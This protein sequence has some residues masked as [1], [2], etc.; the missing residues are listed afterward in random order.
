MADC[1]VEAGQLTVGAIATQPRHNGEPAFNSHALVL[2]FDTQLEPHRSRTSV[3]SSFLRRPFSGISLAS[4]GSES[5]SSDDIRGPLGLCLLHEPP[6]PLIDF[7]FVHGL[8][9]G[10]R[11]TWSKTDDPT[12]FWPKAWLPKEPRFKNVRIF[13]FGYNSN[14]IN[15]KG[16]TLTIHDFGQALLGDIQ[17]TLSS[18]RN[19]SET[20]L[21][22][23]AHSMGGVIIK[24]VLLLAKQD[25]LYHR[26]AARTHSMFFLA[27]PHRGADSAQLLSNMLTIAVSHGSKPYVDNLM[28]GSDAIQVINDGFRHVLQGIQLWS[29][30]E[31]VKTSLGLIVPKDSAILDLPGERVQLSNAD[32]R[33]ICKFEDPSD[34]NYC[35]LRNAF[36]STIDCIENTWY[37]DKQ[38]D[39]R[40]EMTLLSTYLGLLETPDVDLAN[41]LE[42][43]TE[44]TCRWITES[45]TFQ[46]WRLGLEDEPK[47]YWL[48]GDPATGKSTLAG[49]VVQHLEETQRECSYFFFKNSSVGRSTVAELLRSLAWQMASSISAVRQ[50]L[51]ALQTDGVS[52]DKDDERSIRRTIFVARIFRTDLRQPHYWIID[53][54]DECANPTALFPLLSKIEKQYPLLVFLTSRPSLVFERYLSQEK[55]HHFSETAGL[56][57]SLNDITL[58]ISAHAHYIPVETDVERDELSRTILEKSRGNFLWVRLILKELEAAVSKQ[59]ISEILESVPKEIDDLYTRILGKLMSSARAT[60]LVT[61]TLRWVVCASRPLTVDEMKDVLRLEIGE[62]LP[63]LEKTAT[64]ICGNLIY[65]DYQLKIRL[66]HHTVREY[67]SRETS[68]APFSI[69]RTNVHSQMARFCLKYLRSEEMKTLRRGRGSLASRQRQRSPISTYVTRHFSD[70]LARSSSSED[71]HLLDLYAFLKGNSL[72]WLEIVAA[73]QDLSPVVATAKNLKTYLERRARYLPPI[74]KE[75]QSVSGWANDMI[76]VVAQY[77]KIMLTSPTAVHFLIP[78][79][80][81]AG[82]II[83]ELF[84]DQNR[85]LQVAGLSEVQWDD[86]LCTISFAKAQILAVVCRDNKYALGLSDGFVNMYDESSF[87][88][89]SKLAHGEPVRVLSFSSTNTYLASAGRKTI[90]MWNSSTAVLIWTV[91]ISEQVL[92]LDFVGNDRILMAATKMNSLCSWDVETGSEEDKVRFSDIDE[93]DQSDYYYKRPPLYAEISPSLNLLGVA[94]KN[95]PVSFWDLED[96]VFVGQYHKDGAAFPEALVQDF[97]FNPNPELSLVA[98]VYEDGQVDTFDPFT[99]MRESTAESNASTLASS[100]DGTVLLSGSSDG[101]IRIYEFET[102]KLCYQIN[103]DQQYIRALAFDSNNI[104]FLDIRSKQC[105]VW[106]PSVLVRRRGPEDDSSLN[107]SASLTGGPELI[108][109]RIFD[110]DLDITAIAAYDG[111]DCV[112]CGRENGSVAL[113]S[114]KTGQLVQE[115]FTL[116]TFVAVIYFEWNQQESLLVAL[117][118][119]GGYEIQRLTRDALGQFSSSVLFRRL[120]NDVQQLLL[121]PDGAQLLIS[122]SEADELWTT[123]SNALQR[124]LNARPRNTGRWMC[125][126]RSIGKLLF[127]SDKRLRIFDWEN[128]DEL[129]KGEGIDLKMSSAPTQPLSLCTS[130]PRGQNI[131]ACFIGTETPELVPALRLWPSEKLDP[132]G[133]IAEPAAAYDDLA[134]EIKHVVGIYK[135]LLVFLNHQGWICSLNIDDISVDGFYTRHFFIPLQWH[136]TAAEMPIMVTSKGVIMI[137]VKHEVA[138]F[139]NGFDFSERVTFEGTK[140]SAKASMRSVFKGGNSDPP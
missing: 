24:K 136:G 10:S 123:E 37:S 59:H 120:T 9:G 14:W 64:S 30:F 52:I 106:E 47:N 61:T 109:T 76:R 29:F 63:Q 78:P 27:T 135:S 54:L 72:T 44:G 86:R 91:E 119:S 41:V 103:S 108:A 125:H 131:C 67:L 69:Q 49:H 26:I 7:I 32:H 93:E 100:H 92:A 6:E 79:V 34:S 97:I 82:T 101:L 134:K 17:T 5:E 130:S 25:P 140:I 66:A 139:Q 124:S 43:R 11:K 4:R 115:L 56:D 50:K 118:R 95:R 138:V 137:A 48:A 110:D 77:G 121:S 46:T 8:R 105:N 74:G 99:Q 116:T 98:I 57:S 73:S 62:V 90:C 65:V 71:S 104:R 94:Y 55:I 38:Q 20:P 12:H 127:I 23:V 33:N 21:V 3:G 102:L 40:Q 114:S 80:C 68:L 89:H 81:P 85:G 51:M 45:D 117:D 128:L 19:G 84:C 35:T 132:D 96:N 58:L 70:H 36:V 13:S 39:H 1:F 83:H 87:Q 28:P 113:Y 60:Q 111:V 15:R 122:T 107:F 126:P 31:T 75:I 2:M 18:R 22:L 133:V 129:T 112:I 88:I 16:S 53:G 42:S